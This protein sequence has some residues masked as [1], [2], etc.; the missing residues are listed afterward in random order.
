MTVFSSDLLVFNILK[1]CV[2][3]LKCDQ[4]MLAIDL[5]HCISNAS[6]LLFMSFVRV[7]VSLPYVAIGT[8]KALKALNF[9]L[10]E[11][12]LLDQMIHRL[13]SFSLAMLTEH[14]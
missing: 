3:V 7:H 2:F 12:C 13:L 11:R 8:I 1:T 9:S 6:I 10:C 4:C 5:K 14:C